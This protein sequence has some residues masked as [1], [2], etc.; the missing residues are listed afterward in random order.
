MS[1]ELHDAG[2]KTKLPMIDGVDGA[3]EFSPDGK[4]RYWLSRNWSMRRFSDG[5]CRYALWIGMNPSTASADVDDPTIRREMAFTKA[6]MIDCYVKCN[7]MDY[8]ATNPKELVKVSPCSDKNLEC[9]VSM[10]ENAD[11][12]ILAYGALPKSLT[13]YADRV[14]SVL[15]PRQL[16]CMGKTASGSPRHPLYLK[17]TTQCEPWP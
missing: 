2:G 16:W 1:A 15:R 5:R 7:V 17:G 8:R 14:L 12:I 9:I 4:Y 3:A 6:M 11:R 13:K 10:A